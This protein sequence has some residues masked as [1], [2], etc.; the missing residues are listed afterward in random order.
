M[1]ATDAARC[2]LCGT[3]APLYR[4]DLAGFSLCRRCFS[5]TGRQPSPSSLQLTG[6]RADNAVTKVRE[7]DST[8]D[9]RDGQDGPWLP[10]PKLTQESPAL[11][12]LAFLGIIASAIES[13]DA[14]GKLP[15]DVPLV[16]LCQLS[17]E[18][19]PWLHAESMTALCHMLLNLAKTPKEINASRSFLRQLLRALAKKAQPC[20]GSD[21]VGLATELQLIGLAHGDRALR[22]RAEAFATTLRGGDITTAAEVLWAFLTAKAVEMPILEAL[23][24]LETL[25]V[26]SLGSNGSSNAHQ[27]V[28]ALDAVA[29]ILCGL[30]Q[31]AVMSALGEKLD[32]L[33]EDFAAFL[34][35]NC[36]V[37]QGETHL[38]S[39]PAQTFPR[40]ALALSDLLQRHGKCIAFAMPRTSQALEAVLSRAFQICQIF[41][42]EELS[43]L[44]VASCSL[45]VRGCFLHHLVQELVDR[46]HPGSSP[47]LSRLVPGAAVRL[48]R[49]VGS[50]R[51]NSQ[52]LLGEFYLA[53]GQWRVWLDG[54][55][56]AD[57]VD[58]REDGLELLDGGLRPKGCCHKCWRLSKQLSDSGCL[59]DLGG[60]FRI[61]QGA[62]WVQCT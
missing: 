14:S 44:A 34:V 46:C 52:G 55:V 21:Y 39:L 30:A 45:S 27:S 40:L 60:H 18:C 17:T 5:A 41:T 36:K 37:A 3:I 58:V 6:P 1:A 9:G 54:S 50:V 4:S 28:D 42:M 49:G 35:A 23:G 19:L 24:S 31:P 33:A 12:S 59:V 57:C 62:Q 8:E 10:W 2:S 26:K 16:E 20:H 56:D 29:A 61:F 13:W 43:D 15:A 22:D 53:R 7:A 32:K 11:A 38:A 48:R 47:S 51:A 25:D